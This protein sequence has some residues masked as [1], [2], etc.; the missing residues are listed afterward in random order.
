MPDREGN[1]EQEEDAP[2][3]GDDDGF[4]PGEDE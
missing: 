3:E 4:E 1:A 2:E